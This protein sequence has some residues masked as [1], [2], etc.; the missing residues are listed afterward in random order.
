MTGRVYNFI[1]ITSDLGHVHSADL[2]W[3]YAANAINP[4]TWRIGQPSRIFVNR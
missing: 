1:A 3:E 4:L 2:I